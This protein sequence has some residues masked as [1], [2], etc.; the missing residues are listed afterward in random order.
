M[1][2]H[3]VIVPDATR[4]LD[5]ARALPLALSNSAEVI[6]GLGL[7]RKMTAVELSR[8]ARVC[9]DHPIFQ[10]DPDRP[11]DLTAYDRITCVGVV[12]P[13][14]YAGFS[15]GVKGV[16]IGCGARATIDE[17]HALPM[18][19]ACGARVGWIDGNPFQQRLWELAQGLPPIDAVFEVPGHP[20]LITG[21][22]R[23]A[24]DEAVALARGLHFQL[25]DAP[26]ESM[27]LR[28]PPA[29]AAN[30][31]QAS[32]A[33]TYVA[34]AESPALL[35]GGTLY[36][37]APCPEGIG[38]GSGE[39]AC[40]A[41]MKLGRDE[42]LRRLYS[43]ETPPTVGGQQRAYVLA[44]ALQHAHIVLLGAP[45]IPELAALGIAQADFT[46]HADLV[47]HDPFH[48]IPIA[49]HDPTTSQ[50]HNGL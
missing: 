19:R 45:P 26:V 46:P 30:F 28:V 9:A 29:K 38:T 12:E 13:H 18:L 47:V 49:H 32:R 37:D 21:P 40:A 8:L 1:T 27:L 14:Q 20:D 50:K 16:V 2:R 3:A 41:A 43:A 11:I 33:A 36:I 34:L 7:H 44:M 48:H 31:Y 42:L 24:F 10:H 4:P 22:V 35:Q 39:R 15:G 6:V 25:L 23:D 17:M 5:V